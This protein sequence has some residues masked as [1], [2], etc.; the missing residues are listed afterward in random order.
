MEVKQTLTTKFHG[1]Y[2]WY[3]QRRKDN[4]ACLTELGL[5]LQ[6]VHEELLGLSVVDYCEGPIPDRDMPG[7]LW[8]F[9]KFIRG[10]EV[11][12]K[13]KLAT[14]GQLKQLKLVRVVSFHFAKEPL[15]YPYKE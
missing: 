4:E 7:D 12:I 11:Y 8:M 5:T 1:K 13:L 3:L 14:L 10:R 9:G 15:S 6:D 2:L